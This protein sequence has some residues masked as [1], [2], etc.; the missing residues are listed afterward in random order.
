[1]LERFNDAK[2]GIVQVSV[3]SYESDRNGLMNMFLRRRERFPS[4]PCL[5]TL[6][7]KGGADGECVKAEYGAE[8]GNEAL[9]FEE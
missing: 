2:I 3:F 5:D 9:G 7:D 6:F 8:V 1:M 4:M